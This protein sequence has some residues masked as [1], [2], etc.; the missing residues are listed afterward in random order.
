[1]RARVRL[2]HASSAQVRE[3]CAQILR[4]DDSLKSARTDGTRSSL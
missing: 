3:V 4:R 2:L 1:M